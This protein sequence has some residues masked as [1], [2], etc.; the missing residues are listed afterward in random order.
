MVEVTDLHASGSGGTSTKRKG[1]EV[2]CRIS[3]PWCNKDAVY[4][5]IF[6]LTKS[7]VIPPSKRFMA[8]NL[9]LISTKSRV[10]YNTTR[11]SLRYSLLLLKISAEKE[12]LFKRRMEEGY[13]FEDDEYSQWK[14]QQVRIHRILVAN[15]IQ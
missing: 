11:C 9:P 12:E 4:Y 5:I 15:S 13:D 8:S 1:K 7:T 2:M 6:I 3:V 10:S 14:K